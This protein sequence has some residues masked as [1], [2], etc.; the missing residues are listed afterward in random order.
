MK[1]RSTGFS[2][3]MLMLGS[4]VSQPVDILFGAAL[5]T[6]DDV[7]P[8]DYIKQLRKK[9]REIHSFATQKMRSQMQ[10]Q[11]RTYNLKLQ[12]YHYEVGDF[13]F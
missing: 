6:D 4:E 1:N 8:V 11:K 2:T 7:D 9:L 5:R 10:Y 12:E 13:V 3:N